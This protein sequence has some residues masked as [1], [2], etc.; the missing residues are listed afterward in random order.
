MRCTSSPRIFGT[1]TDDTS[2]MFCQSSSDPHG[3]GS[4]APRVAQVITCF[5]RRVSD[6][7]EKGGISRVVPGTAPAR[8]WRP[9]RRREEP[10]FAD[11]SPRFWKQMPV[12]QRSSCR[13]PSPMEPRHRRIAGDCPGGVLIYDDR[14]RHGDVWF[15]RGSGRDTRIVGRSPG[16]MA[17]GCTDCV[18]GNES[19]GRWRTSWYV[20]H[21]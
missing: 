1:T 17:R 11:A 4:R 6:R 20:S 19:D 14:C 8:P 13:I 21:N 18:A 15:Y 9:S 7:E 12:C 5:I 16:R 10:A 3:E 2:S